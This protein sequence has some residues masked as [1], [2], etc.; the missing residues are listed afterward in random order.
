MT[1]IDGKTFF[2]A[3][4]F[5]AV[6][7]QGKDVAGAEAAEQIHKLADL[8]ERFCAENIGGEPISDDE[9][10][11]LPVDHRISELPDAERRHV[12]EDWATLIVLYERLRQQK[13]QR[14]RRGSRHS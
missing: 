9:P 14:S 10:S 13:T 4:A 5:F 6:V 1:G 2:T 12:L 7:A 3:F 11:A 8:A